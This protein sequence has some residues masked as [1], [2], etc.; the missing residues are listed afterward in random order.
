[1]ASSGKNQILP[2]LETLCRFCTVTQDQPWPRVRASVDRFQPTTIS[3]QGAR[4]I[5]S[6]S[7]CATQPATTINICFLRS[8]LTF[9]LRDG[10]IRKTFQ[11]LFHEYGRCS[12]SPYLRTKSRLFAY[13]LRA[14]EHLSSVQSHRRSSGNQ[15][16]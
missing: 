2:Q 3:T 13:S 12:K 9:S 14:Q 10:L 7:A 5:S 16:S 6:P 4:L 1:M 8:F 15:K 11:K